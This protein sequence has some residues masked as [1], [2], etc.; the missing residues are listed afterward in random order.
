MRR[1]TRVLKH[2]LQLG[3]VNVLVVPDL[4]QVWL[5]RDVRGEEQDVIDWC[6]VSR[7]AERIGGS[8][9]PRVRPI[10]RSKARGS[11]CG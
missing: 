2:G 8:P 11:G 1:L 7:E 9:Y 4:V 3:L 5:D 6:P 10:C